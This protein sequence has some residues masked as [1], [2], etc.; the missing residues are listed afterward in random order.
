MA[1][2]D[3]NTVSKNAGE[4]GGVAAKKQYQEPAFRF[5]QVFETMALACG[6]VQPTNFLCLHKRMSS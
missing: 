4:S 3:G 5:E 2:Q 1:G 6:K